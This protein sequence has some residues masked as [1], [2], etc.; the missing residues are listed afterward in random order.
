MTFK[1]YEQRGDKIIQ[2]LFPDSIITSNYNKF[3]INDFVFETNRNFIVGEIKTRNDNSTRY[4]TYILEKNKLESLLKKSLKYKEY[5]DKEIQ[6]IYIMSFTDK[7]IHIFDLKQVYL[8]IQSNLLQKRLMSLPDSTA[9]CN[10]Y[11]QKEIYMI[12]NKHILKTIYLN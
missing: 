4:D 5:I 10:N 7:I 8:D 6:V 3:S 12:E 2:T 1:D 9:Y 11:I